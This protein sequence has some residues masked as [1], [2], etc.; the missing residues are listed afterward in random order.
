MIDS[1][2]K[3]NGMGWNGLEMEGGKVTGYIYIY[4]IIPI[5]LYYLPFFFL[6]IWPVEFTVAAA[7][8]A[9]MESTEVAVI[10]STTTSSGSLG[11]GFFVG[12]TRSN[13]RCCSVVRVS[14]NSTVN[15]M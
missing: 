14:G 3:W 2:K 13:P 4:I 12:N 6:L 15:S 9:R 5:I 7:A 1:K 10:L 8:A 11:N